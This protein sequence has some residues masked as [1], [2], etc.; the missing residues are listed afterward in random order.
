[1]MFGFCK[2]LIS[3]FPKVW[4]WQNWLCNR[5]LYDPGNEHWNF[6]FKDWVLWKQSGET[7][8]ANPR[9]KF[10]VGFSVCFDSWEGLP[11]YLDLVFT[12]F[13]ME[14]STPIS[15]FL[16]C[17]VGIFCRLFW[18]TYLHCPKC[19]SW[20]LNIYT[21]AD[22][23]GW[24]CSIWN[25]QEAMIEADFCNCQKASCNW[26]L[27]PVGISTTMC[28]MLCTLVVWY[29]QFLHCH[30]LVRVLVFFFWWWIFSILW[31]FL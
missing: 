11:T 26:S 10:K 28:F 17:S 15:V 2:S 19:F 8:V 6:S 24:L 5:L 7:L 9:R 13:P 29:R 25:L 20:V 23:W 12:E 4:L 22:P 27:P 16:A 21:N 3:P 18:C 30:S 1:M 31:L 14:I